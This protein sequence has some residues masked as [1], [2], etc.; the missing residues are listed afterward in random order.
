MKTARSV[1]YCSVDQMGSNYSVFCKISNG[2]DYK[3][4]FQLATEL[5][6]RNMVS[7]RNSFVDTC[8][9]APRKRS[10]SLIEI[11]DL[12]LLL[13]SMDS[14]LRSDKAGDRKWSQWPTGQCQEE[15]SC[16][17]CLPI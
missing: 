14:W 8:T 13:M 15:T 5:T 1:G 3:I 4:Q 10:V 11:A 16:D 2:D 17:L 9:I 12:W 7:T 6:C